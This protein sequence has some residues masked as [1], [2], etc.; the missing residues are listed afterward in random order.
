MTHI[1]RTSPKVWLRLIPTLLASGS[2]DG[3]EPLASQL[4]PDGRN[5]T[6][7]ALFETNCWGCNLRATS[8]VQSVMK[9]RAI[10][11]KHTFSRVF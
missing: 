2:L 5:R 7:T 10:Q 9:E 11:E 3:A 1:S 6:P 8:L 4:S